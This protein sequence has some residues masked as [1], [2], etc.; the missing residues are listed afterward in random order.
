MQ[1]TAQF[2][3]KAALPVP[4]AAQMILDGTVKGDRHHFFAKFWSWIHTFYP[5][6]PARIEDL[7][8]K[9]VRKSHKAP[10]YGN[11]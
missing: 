10:R 6:C 7:I 5:C 4:V 9:G 3:Q 8:V 1:E 2:D 11:M